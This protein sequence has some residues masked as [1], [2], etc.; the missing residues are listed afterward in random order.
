[1]D[2]GCCECGCGSSADSGDVIDGIDTGVEALE[3]PWPDRFV[4]DD[5]SSCDESMLAFNAANVGSGGIGKLCGCIAFTGD[6]LFNFASK[7]FKCLP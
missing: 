4:A 2:M 1:M 7:L 5:S 3:A 6:R